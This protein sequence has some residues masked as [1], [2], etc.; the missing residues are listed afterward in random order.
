MKRFVL[1]TACSVLLV[2]CAGSSEKATTA[3]QTSHPS[4]SP[5]DLAA[6]AEAV[7]KTGD[8]PATLVVGSRAMYVG[9]HRTGSV[10]R[11]D[12]T[13]NTVTGEVAVGG[14]LNLEQNP[15]NAVADGTP[16][17]ACTNVDGVLNQVSTTQSKV[18]AMVPA[19]CDGGTR[20]RIGRTLWAV[21]GPDTHELLVL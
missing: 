5:S 9:T 3:G 11:I 12:P 7:V 19:K 17:W 18:L 20:T 2:A 16:L 8:G 1:L 4:A 21:S 6:Q 14:Q 15:P 13:T 10:Q